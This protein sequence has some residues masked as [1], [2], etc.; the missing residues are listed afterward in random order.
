MAKTRP[1][2]ARIFIILLAA[3]ASFRMKGVDKLLETIDQTALLRRSAMTCCD[4]CSAGVTVVLRAPD[5]ARRKVLHGLPVRILE[6]PKW[7]TGMA[8]SLVAGLAAQ[9][10]G[11]DA[12]LVVLADMPDIRTA[13]LDRV[14]AGFSPSDGKTICQARSEDGQPGHPVLFG[15]QHFAALAALQNDSGGRSILRQNPDAVAY[16]ATSGQSA[17]RDLDTAQDWSDYRRRNAR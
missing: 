14:M 16:I 1:E 17:V 13:D 11:C 6:N 12:V 15:R 5:L 10:A 2:P 3:G 9:P 7:Q 4:S 8:S